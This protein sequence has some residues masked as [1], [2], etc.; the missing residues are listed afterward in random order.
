MNTLRTALV[1][2]VALVFGI[3]L[4]ARGD[5]KKADAR[6]NV[7]FIISDDLT[8]HRAFLLRQHGLPD[9]EHRP[10]RRA[11]HAL[12]PGLLPGHLLRAV[13]GVVHVRLLPARDRSAGLHEARGRRS[14]TAPPGRSISRTPATTP[15]GSARSFTWACPAG[16]RRASDGADDP[17]V[18]DRAIQ[19]PGPGVEGAGR[20]RDAGGQSRRQEAGGRRQHLRRGR[21]RRRRPGPLRRQD[22]GQGRAN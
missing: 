17:A 13:A 6:F 19:Q 15:P 21:G 8:A 20:R 12:H 18:V 14:A 3:S 7:L 11:R 16:S 22:R 4:P 9:A 1:V 2:F 10:P 5:A